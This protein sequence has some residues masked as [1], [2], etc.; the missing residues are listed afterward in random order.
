MAPISGTALAVAF[1]IVR[2]SYGWQKKETGPLGWK[3]MARKTGRHRSGVQ[4]SCAELLEA[5]IVTRRDAKN[6]ASLWAIVK[7][8]DKWGATLVAPG[9]T[10]PAP[11]ATR[12][13]PAEAAAGEGL[14]QQPRGA[15]TAAPG[16][17]HSGPGGAAT[18][19]PRGRRYKVLK[20]T[21]KKTSG[22]RRRELSTIVDNL[23][24]TPDLLEQRCTIRGAYH[25]LTF[26]SI[27]HGD[28][29]YLLKKMPDMGKAN[30][31]GLRARIAQHEKDMERQ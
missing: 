17:R 10:Q 13:A 21:V 25:G 31:E 9:A 20:E 1:L 24:I 28:A 11:G 19:G 29:E 14:L 4:K 30:R 15:T 18:V 23:G 7:D 16:G 12:I 3:L 5:G 22:S 6:G 2:E 26:G 27:P 8:F